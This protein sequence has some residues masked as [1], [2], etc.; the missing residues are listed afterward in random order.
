M[1]IG[2][3][4]QKTDEDDEGRIYIVEVYAKDVSYV[5]FKCIRDSFG[6]IQV[7]DKDLRLAHARFRGNYY[8][9]E[10]ENE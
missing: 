3:M 7:G 10:M 2:G 9:L 8:L 1:V 6:R 5:Y 4:Y